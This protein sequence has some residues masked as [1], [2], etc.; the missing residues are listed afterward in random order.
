MSE[1]NKYRPIL[2]VTISS[3]ASSDDARLRVALTEIAKQDPT[4]KID[5]EAVDGRVVAAGMT[6][7]HLEAIGDRLLHEYKLM[8]NVSEPNVTY[9]E[10]IRKIG[11][12][13][14]STSARPAG[15]AT[16]DI[17]NSVSSPMGRARATSSSARSLMA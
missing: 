7:S 11:R 9:L 16:T 12:P 17:A 1:P 15:W 13:K 2:F 8:V 3:L 4:I 14:E 10:T 5:A 6:Q